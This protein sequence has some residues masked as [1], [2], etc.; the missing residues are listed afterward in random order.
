MSNF[1]QYYGGFVLVLVKNRVEDKESGGGS[2]TAPQ[3]TRPAPPTTRPPP[4]SRNKEKV[5]L[6]LAAACYCCLD[7]TLNSKGKCVSGNLVVIFS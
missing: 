7:S 6:I 4:P 5:N 1:G 2:R 3:P